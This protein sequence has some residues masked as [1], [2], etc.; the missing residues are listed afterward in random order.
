M[1]SAI[2]GELA[3]FRDAYGAHRA[4]EGRAHKGG[5]LFDLPYLAKGPLARQWGVRART[6]D[7]FMRRLLRPMAAELGR[8]VDLVDLGAGNGWLCYRAAMEGHRCTAL[9][10]R[11]D[12]VDGLGASGEYLAAKPGL[13]ERAISSF[14]SL[15]LPSHAV[16]L[17]VFNASLHYALDLAVTLKEAVRVVRPGGMVVILDSPF[18]RS[19]RAGAAMAAEKKAQSGHSFGARAGELLALPFVEYLTR[20]SL[21]GASAALGLEW[22]RHRILYPLWYE[23]RP[24]AAALRRRRPPSRFDMW[25]ARRP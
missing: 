7:A 5:E 18:Y 4:A 20:D 22:R 21:R 12:E 9:D 3:R 6:F 25:S 19:E 2:P 14:D 23:L 11:E 1:E 17:A 24:L 10:I 8:P 13:F 16:D 15:P